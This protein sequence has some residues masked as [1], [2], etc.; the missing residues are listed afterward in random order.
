MKPVEKEA[1]IDAFCN[2]V[3]SVPEAALQKFMD[4][5]CIAGDDSSIYESSEYYTPIMDALGVWYSAKL[6]YKL[7]FKAEEKQND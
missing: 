3:A 4:D 7:Y 2:N 6:F 1:F 5:Y